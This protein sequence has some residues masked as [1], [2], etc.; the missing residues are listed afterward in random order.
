ML[1]AGK[2]QLVQV[3]CTAQHKLCEP[4]LSGEGGWWWGGGL[5]FRCNRLAPDTC[6]QQWGVSAGATSSLLSVTSRRLPQVYLQHCIRPNANAAAGFASASLREFP[7]AS[8]VAGPREGALTLPSAICAAEIA[9]DFRSSSVHHVRWRFG[10]KCRVHGLVWCAA[11]PALWGSRGRVS[12]LPRDEARAYA[13][14]LQSFT[15]PVVAESSHKSVRIR[16]RD[17]C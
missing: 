7:P 9:E 1:P 3:C 16:P 11:R 14:R 8:T 2:C 15:T 13:V 5:P 17:L 4:T 10:P 6:R 12:H